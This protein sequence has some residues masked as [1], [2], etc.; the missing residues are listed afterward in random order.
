MLQT[1]EVAPDFTLLSDENRPVK[2]SDYRGQRVILFFYPKA[3][4]SG[5]TTQACGFRD[6]F[7]I[8]SESGA[9]VLGISPDGVQVL[10]KWRQKRN[11]PYALLSDSDHAV[12]ETYGVWG[13]KSMFGKKYMGIIRSHFVVDEEGKLA[14]VQV[15]VSPEESVAQAMKKIKTMK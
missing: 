12:A 13:Q 1:G 15:K 6:N 11:L 2:L 7:P 10:A 8:F 4:T 14:D 3:D 9:V 5:C